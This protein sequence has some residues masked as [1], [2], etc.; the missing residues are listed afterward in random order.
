MN[1][2]FKNPGSFLCYRRKPPGFFVCGHKP[3]VDL[4][5]IPDRCIHMAEN[6]LNG[7]IWG[8]DVIRWTCWIPA[9]SRFTGPGRIENHSGKRLI[10]ENQRL[11][12]MIKILFVCHGMVLTQDKNPW[13]IRLFPTLSSEFTT[14][15]RHS[16]AKLWWEFS[17]K[18]SHYIWKT[19]L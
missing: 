17:C 3:F 1:A 15:L 4:S 19:E 12:Q 11:S 16:I 2:V 9:S 5:K 14:L 6:L 13:Y 7:G 10:T 8:L 18:R